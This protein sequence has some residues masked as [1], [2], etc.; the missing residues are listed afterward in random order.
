MTFDSV[1]LVPEYSFRTG[2]LST[3]SLYVEDG[4]Q[5]VILK[6]HFENRSTSA[7]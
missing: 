3:V 6:G 2:D 7:I 5:L 1:E 4:Y